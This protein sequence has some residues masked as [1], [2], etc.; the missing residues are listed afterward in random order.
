MRVSR[1]KFAYLLTQAESRKKIQLEFRLAVRSAILIFG[2]LL[3]WTPYA[4]VC[5]YRAFF[6][7]DGVR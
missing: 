1:E 3:S 4:L 6:D 5:L 7:A 2:F